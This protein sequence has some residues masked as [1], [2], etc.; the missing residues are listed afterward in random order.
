MD[1]KTVS[2]GMSKTRGEEVYVQRHKT[3]AGKGKSNM[4]FYEQA[5]SRL[6]SRF[7]RTKTHLHLDDSRYTGS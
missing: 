4:T 6:K 1:G 3:L 5:E 2:S 7:D